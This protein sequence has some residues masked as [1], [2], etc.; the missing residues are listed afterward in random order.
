MSPAQKSQ[1]ILIKRSQRS[2]LYDAANQRYVSVEQLRG[3]TA[4]R[5]AFVVLDTETGADVTRVLPRLTRVLAARSAVL[6]FPAS[7][8]IQQR[9]GGLIS[10]SST[11]VCS[12]AHPWRNGFGSAFR[13][14]KAK[15]TPAS[16][17]RER[18]GI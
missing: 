18:C 12:R 10:V 14:P 8:Q 17:R 4:D 13:T 16:R 9:S 2:R 6:N 5:V 1:P 3:W 11:T 7:R 15:F